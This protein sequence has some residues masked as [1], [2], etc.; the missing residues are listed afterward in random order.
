M[1]PRLV[2]LGRDARIASSTTPP[3]SGPP[4]SLVEAPPPVF[5]EVEL[6]RFSVGC[7]PAFLAPVLPSTEALVP[8][9]D[10][11]LELDE[12]T[13][14]QPTFR[15]YWRAS[16][17]PPPAVATPARGEDE[18]DEEYSDGIDRS[19]LCNMVQLSADEGGQSVRMMMELPEQLTEELRPEQVASSDPD[20]AELRLALVNRARAELMSG[21]LE[22]ADRTLERAEALLPEDPLVLVHR[23]WIRLLHGEAFFAA[24]QAEQAVANG[25]PD[26]VVEALVDA[27]SVEVAERLPF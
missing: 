17:P 26:R 20:T 8:D 15:G 24:W 27:L 2:R 16:P 18:S 3:R 11:T 9:L 1:P 6:P 22:D 7:M 12:D 14:D 21:Q 5:E 13:E 25:V 23:A 19:F 4:L 10:E